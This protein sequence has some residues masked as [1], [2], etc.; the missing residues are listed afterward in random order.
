MDLVYLAT[1]ATD[2]GT[3]PGATIAIVILLVGLAAFAIAFLVVGPGRRRAGR[4]RMGDIPLAMRPY[5][6]DEELE[7]TALERAMAWGVALS[8]FSAVFLAVYWWIEP[9]RINDKVDQFYRD[10][11]TAGHALYINNCA[12]CH[13]NDAGGGSAPNPYSDAPWPAPALHNVQAR[14]EGSTIVT[15]VEQFLTTTIKQGRPGTPMP[16]WGA[17]YLGPLN[18]QEVEDIVTYL[19]AIQSGE[20]DTVDAQAFVGASGEDVW[21]A[22]CARCHGDALQG[23]VGPQLLNVFERYGAKDGN[24]DSFEAVREM[25]RQTVR[26]GRYV[27]TGAIMPQFGDDELPAD[28]LEAVIEY[29]ESQQVTGG[30]RYGQIGGD[31]TPAGEE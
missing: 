21:T 13:G 15:D 3:N 7:T 12:T 11:V 25:I 6:S 27:P 8:L 19:M 14:Y 16:A 17:A 22:N 5:H 30:P 23:Q 4:K 9:W 24:E 1:E 10:D 20:L 26:V 2:A 29:I 18:D 31:P 28:A